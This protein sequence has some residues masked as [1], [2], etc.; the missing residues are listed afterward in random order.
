MTGWHRGRLGILDTETTG[1]DVETERIV[2]ATVGVVGG[3]EPTQVRTWLI[4]PGV[5]IPQGAIDV[6]GITN[7]KAQDHGAD[8]AAALDEIGA[9]LLAIW[10]QGFPVIAFN[11]A[12]D[13]TILDREL[14]RH[15]GEQLDVAGPVVDPFVLDRAVDKYRRGKRTLTAT[16]QHYGVRLDGAHDATQDA[17]AAARVA[18]ALANR[19]PAEVGAKSLAELHDLQVGWHAERQADFRAYLER[20]GKDAS[21]VHGDWPMRPRVA[22]AA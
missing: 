16:C 13:L 2:T 4:N 1:V 18:W 9:A 22:V 19:Y 7:E 17:L 20:Q 15:L 21:D 12:F 8:P 6:H 10:Q 14:D 3:G 5:E 11:A